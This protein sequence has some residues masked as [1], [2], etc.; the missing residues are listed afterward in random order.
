MTAV[1]M[2]KRDGLAAA[3]AALT[4]GESSIASLGNSITAQ[5]VGYRPVLHTRLEALTGHHHQIQAFPA[6]R[7]LAG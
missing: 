7:P 3:P 1:G 2:R 4:A 6:P 5:K